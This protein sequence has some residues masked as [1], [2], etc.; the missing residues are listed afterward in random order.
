MSRTIFQIVI[1][2]G[3][4][5]L[6]LTGGIGCSKKQPEQQTQQVEQAPQVA[7]PQYVG[8][9]DEEGKAIGSALAAIYTADSLYSCPMHPEV[10]TDHPGARCPQCGMNLEKMPD[11]KVAELRASSPKGCPGCAYV[12][13][14]NS[15]VT[16]CP[17]CGAD[18]VEAAKPDSTGH[19][20]HMHE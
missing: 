15:E 2:A 20:G 19:E 10:V 4:A 16:K 5:A 8:S 14:G 17:G 7:E 18:L 1:L 6:L 12:V 13:P 9:V 11:E 3:I